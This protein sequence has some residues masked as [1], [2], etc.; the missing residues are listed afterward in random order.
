MPELF[1]V[2]GTKG[3]WDKESINLAKKNH[4]DILANPRM[5]RGDKLYS[6][7][8]LRRLDRAMPVVE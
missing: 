7:D 1:T 8:M 5:S 4:Q 3:V 2:A 6:K